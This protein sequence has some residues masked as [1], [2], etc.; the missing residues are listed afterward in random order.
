MY[1]Y[2]TYM[3]ILIYS[4]YNNY[5]MLTRLSEAITLK[6]IRYVLQHS[7]YTYVYLSVHP[8]L[9]GTLPSALYY[10]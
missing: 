7:T 9:K 10:M 5:N 8:L 1:I 6:L 3:D 4:I 2:K